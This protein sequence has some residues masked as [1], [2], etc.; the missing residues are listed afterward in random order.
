MPRGS[1]A[2]FSG[3]VGVV[4]QDRTA[5]DVERARGVGRV[6]AHRPPQWI[7]LG[8]LIA[9]TAAIDA[10]Y[11]GR[12]ARCRAKFLLPGD[13]LPRRASRSSRSSTR[14]RRVHELL[15]RPHPHEVEAITQ[16]ELTSLQPPANGK[17]YFMAPARNADGDLVLVL[18]DQVSGAT[19]VGTEEGPDAARRRAT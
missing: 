9:A 13:A 5:R 4:R 2:F 15:D 14:R 16:I 18:E 6:R 1:I 12:G 3:S 17:Q 8:V 7:A 19:F 11:F 10:I